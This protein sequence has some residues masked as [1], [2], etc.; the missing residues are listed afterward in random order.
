MCN[1]TLTSVLLAR[2]GNCHI[3]GNPDLY[4]LGIRVGIYIQMITVQ[5]SA[6]LSQVLREE[7]RL[8]EATVVFVIS[9]SSVLFNLIYQ[10]KIEAVEAAPVLVLLLAQVHS[11]RL[12]NTRGIIPTLIFAVELLG[13]VGLYVWYWWYGMDTLKRTCPDDK[14]FF[15]A[16]VS[17]W[18]WFRT[19]NKV[20]TVF[21]AIYGAM[22]AIMYIF[23]GSIP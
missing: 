19:M 18:G 4:G 8:N 3:E 2:D 20:L 7:D 22:A 16:K 23:G 13:L 14:A 1:E 10:N 12:V 15:F 11:C 6:A 21:T 17:I 5:I 9:V